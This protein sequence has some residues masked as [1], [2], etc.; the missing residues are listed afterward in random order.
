MQTHEIK[1]KCVFDERFPSPFCILTVLVCMLAAATSAGAEDMNVPT[2][3]SWKGC[4]IGTSVL[5]RIDE[6]SYKSKKETTRYYREVL[7]GEDTDGF[8]FVLL[9]YA[10][11]SGSFLKTPSRS[12]Q[13]GQVQRNPAV[14]RTKSEAERDGV[15]FSVVKTE[16]GRG[17]YEQYDYFKYTQT[18]LD[19]R[20][21]LILESLREERDAYKGLTYHRINERRLTKVTR[22]EKF[23]R[24]LV[25]FE[26]ELMD[27]TDGK[28]RL[29][30]YSRLTPSIPKTL[31]YKDQWYDEM[32]QPVGEIKTEVVKVELTPDEVQ[33]HNEFRS[34]R[35]RNEKLSI[36]SEW[37]QWLLRRMKERGYSK[38]KALKEAL[39]W[40]PDRRTYESSYQ[41]AY[42]G[43]SSAWR[44]YTENP[45][46]KTRNGLFAAIEDRYGRMITFGG[47][48]AEV[49]ALAMLE[50]SDKDIR[51]KGIII[52]AKLLPWKYRSL[53]EETM[54]SQQSLDPAGLEVLFNEGL[55]DGFHLANVLAGLD[56]PLKDVQARY[57][58]SAPAAKLEQEVLRRIADLEARS[59]YDDESLFE[60]L[61]SFDSDEVR[62]YVA[63]KANGITKGDFQ[64]P[65]RN[66]NSNKFIS[67]A[68]KLR[69]EGIEALFLQWLDWMPVPSE[70]QQI[71]RNTLLLAGI[72]ARMVYDGLC[73][74]DASVD[75]AIRELIE[76]LPDDQIVFSLALLRKHNEYSMLK[77]L[78]L[79][80]PAARVKSIM[81]SEIVTGWEM[82]KAMKFAP[83]LIPFLCK[84]DR[85]EVLSMFMKEAFVDYRSD[86]DYREQGLLSQKRW[87]QNRTGEKPITMKISCEREPFF[88][89]MANFGED[90]L[91][92][93]KNL[94]GWPSYRKYIHEQLRGYDLDRPYWIEQVT[95]VKEY[96]DDDEFRRELTL[97]CLDSQGAAE[98]LV[99]ML[100]EYDPG[101]W[102]LSDV[103]QAVAHL[104][105]DELLKVAKGR[106]LN[107]KG[108]YPILRAL[109]RHRSKTCAN[110]L[111]SALEGERNASMRVFIGG[112]INRS[113]EKNFGL[114][115]KE[116]RDWIMSLP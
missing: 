87:Y 77:R 34:N 17:P 4:A 85:R 115:K 70:S 48:R 18:T 66:Y 86:V 44:A 16:F 60:M 90:G 9:G 13:S 69:V 1:S 100:G 30:S 79:D 43:V 40:M 50:D 97:L 41:R 73:L 110:I 36:E 75:K 104:P 111:L 46:D 39:Q 55:S 114:R 31:S 10:D 6:I 3:G 102:R 29:H 93:L 78:G 54:I 57:L 99:S 53:L 23:N 56:K 49:I 63:T 27:H 5:T 15:E 80:L 26:I 106:G 8:T 68:C 51:R 95:A 35:P 67:A 103:R 116:M 108:R 113:A 7:I 64:S 83:E 58:G 96:S 65:L 28:L 88:T 112:L 62:S 47:P 45:E 14:K 52:L 89:A 11:E 33:K 20:D 37:G 61:C 107:G 19:G 24:K 101:T 22:E 84:S 74:Y 92:I 76:N 25:V 81:Q 72:R 98:K 21:D 32:G 42:E 91:Q 12:R 109:S 82:V 2:S 71:D 59:G 94:Y 105:Q 38:E